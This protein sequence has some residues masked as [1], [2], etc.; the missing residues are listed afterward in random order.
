MADTPRGGPRAP[1]ARSGEAAGAVA[2]CRLRAPVYPAPV[3]WTRR[4]LLRALGTS[5]AASMLAPLVTACAS[6]PSPSPAP[7]SRV[8]RPVPALREELRRQ[9][10][11]LSR[12]L[13]RVWALA[14]IERVSWVLVDPEE[15]SLGQSSLASLVLGAAGRDGVIEEVTTDLSPGGIA[16][17]AWTLGER[18]AAAGRSADS[19]GHTLPAPRDFASAPAEDPRAYTPGQW[20]APVEALYERA[21]RIR[22]SRI[23]YR[24]AYAVCDD[25]ETVLVSAGQDM[26]QRL[27]RTRAGVLLVSQDMRR[28]VPGEPGR[29][30][31]LRI[32]DVGQGGLQGMEATELRDD[33]LSSA[34]ERVLMLFA[35]T[36][37]PQGELDVVLAPDLAAR[38][39]RDCVAPALCSEP[40]ERG[41]CRAAALAGAPVAAEAV[42][43]LDDPSADGAYGSYFFDDEGQAAAPAG[44]IEAGVLRG[45]LTDARGSRALGAPRTASARRAHSLAPARPAP[46]NLALA[47][48]QHAPGDIIAGVDHGYLLE[49]CLMARAD[50]HTWRF[51]ARAARAYEIRR[52]KLT[53]VV[54]AD[55]E[56]T[57]DV[58][59]L[60]QAVRAVSTE[61]RRFCY[62]GGGALATSASSPHVW[63]RARIAGG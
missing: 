31:T 43:L 13:P 34:A 1:T 38:I 22:E 44:L 62:G 61:A 10:Q 7:M 54:H 60:L 48:G 57:G 35:P 53:G 24:G 55:V 36:A 56:L 52:G 11:G 41:G 30:A 4:A 17:A 45:P 40:W 26:A 18:A 12:R 32:E 20:L 47:P 46:S 16:R 5:A 19:A 2:W 28:H 49:G 29:V 63:T 37:P 6:S 14:T 21:Q 23:V 42:T 25:A 39:L 59:G 50:A 15:R 27:V 9:V 51:A 58:P 3:R 8:A 33:A